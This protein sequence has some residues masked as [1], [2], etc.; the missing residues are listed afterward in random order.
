ML[1]HRQNELYKSLVT[2]SSSWFED[3]IWAWHLEYA[4]WGRLNYICFWLE[5]ANINVEL[6]AF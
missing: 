4:I 6:K 3:T 2:L 5:H 1:H